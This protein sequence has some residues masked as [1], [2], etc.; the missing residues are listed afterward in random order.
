MTCIPP[1]HPPPQPKGIRR[2]LA[3]FGRAQDGATVVEFAFVATPF[4]MLLF[5]I[6]ETALMFWTSQI[7]EESLQQ[8]A[9]SL[10]T[11]QSRTLY[12]GSA[13]ANAT[14]FR[15]DIC[16]RAPTALIDCDKLFIDVRSY[17]SFANAQTGT[18]GSNPVGG[19]ALN[20]NGF[21]YSQPGADQIVVVRAALEYRLFMS[22]WS[23]ALANIGGGKRGLVASAT[24]R[25]EPF[26]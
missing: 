6:V 19:G 23:S 4:L 15:N 2:L 21:T 20:T 13:A 25:T 24:F 16:A 18:S 7:L 14:A 10:L 8:S 26:V 5:A 3:R 11:G 17:N 1:Q 9:R 12:T 22:Q